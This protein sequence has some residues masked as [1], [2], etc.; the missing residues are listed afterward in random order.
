MRTFNTTHSSWIG[1]TSGLVFLR[2]GWPSYFLR[3]LL[4]AFALAFVF[5]A[6]L[7]ISLYLLGTSVHEEADKP[8]PV[9]KSHASNRFGTMRKWLHNHHAIHA[10]R[11]Q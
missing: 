3:E 9:S 2:L 7:W 5:F 4:N 8:G 6:L 1:G 11:Y 10:H